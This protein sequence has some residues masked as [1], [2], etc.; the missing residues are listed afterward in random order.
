MTKTNIL[1]KWR[2]VAV[3]AGKLQERTFRSYAEVELDPLFAGV[4]R[5][6]DRFH[7]V[8][9]TGGSSDLLVTK[10]R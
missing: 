5:N 9:R 1:P 7:Y 4:V 2:V 6:K 8:S 3:V 10:L